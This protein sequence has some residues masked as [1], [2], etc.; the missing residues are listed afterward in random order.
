MP[1]D[2]SGAHQFPRIQDPVKLMPSQSGDHRRSPAVPS[3]YQQQQQPYER[4]KH[5]DERSQM[6]IKAAS[7]AHSFL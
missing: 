5:P 1:P 4:E 6:A 7:T 2:S 3:E